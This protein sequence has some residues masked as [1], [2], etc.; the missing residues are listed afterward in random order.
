MSGKAAQ[1]GGEPVDDPGAP[2]L[3]VLTLQHGVA[4]APVQGEQFS[5]DGPLGAPT[6]GRDG[7]LEVLEQLAVAVG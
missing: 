1:V 3:R 2:A 5:V 7:A 6:G 4:Q